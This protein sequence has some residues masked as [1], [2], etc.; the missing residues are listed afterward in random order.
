MPHHLSPHPNSQRRNHRDTCQGITIISL[1][2]VRAWSP[3]TRPYHPPPA[4]TPCPFLCITLT[5][6]PTLP[7][8][9]IE[10]NR[11]AHLLVPQLCHGVYAA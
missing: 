8:Y 7:T 9:K 11:A 1:G 2:S 5:H 6:A 10:Y 4:R 3:A